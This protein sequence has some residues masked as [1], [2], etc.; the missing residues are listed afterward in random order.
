MNIAEAIV[1]SI[2]I[3][4]GAFIVYEHIKNNKRK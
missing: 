2:S 3:I 1:I 4:C